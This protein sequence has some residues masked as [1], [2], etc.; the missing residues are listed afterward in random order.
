MEIIKYNGS[1]ITDDVVNKNSLTW[2]KKWSLEHLHMLLIAKDGENYLGRIA[3]Y[4]NEFY[5]EERVAFLGA[6]ECIDD[7]NVSE[8]LLERAIFELKKIN[9][10]KI[11]GPIDGS[12]WNSYRFKDNKSEIFFTEPTQPLWYPQQWKKFGFEEFQ[13]YQSRILDLH[14]FK[15][16]HIQGLREELE[17]KNITFRKLNLSDLENELA[18]LINFN[19]NAFRN[20]VLYSPADKAAFIKN[21]KTIL[22]LADQDLILLAEYEKELVGFIFMLP[23]FN[24]PQKETCVLKTLAKKKGKRF[25]KLGWFLSHNAQ[26]I[27]KNKGYKKVIHALMVDGNPS[28]RLS[29]LEK[30]KLHG[31]YKLYSYEIS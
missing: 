13:S 30:S 10:K 29:M 28:I 27:A 4:L 22:A 8:Q 26:L 21:Y 12:T 2:R 23:D 17:E 11:F 1:A 14:T 25:N 31:T 18:I 3:I 20:A 9:I 6:Y 16:D 5:K 19:E 15:T 24:D 7:A